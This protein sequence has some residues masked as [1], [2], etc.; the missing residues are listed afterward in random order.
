MNKKMKLSICVVAYNEEDFL[1]NLIDDI[2]KQK[3]PHDLTE[4]VLIDSMST[5]GTKRIMKSFQRNNDFYSVQVLDNPGKIQ[6]A[7]WNVAIKNATG[8]VISRIDA[9]TILPA[10]F[11][12]LVM[13]NIEAGEDVVGGIRPCVIE[14]DDDWG[15]ILLQVEN[16]LFGSSVN[17][18]RRS[19]EKQ[20]V[21]TMFHASYR[22]EVFEKVGLFNENLLR[23]EDNEMHY[24]IRQA[25]YKLC[26][27]PEIVSYQYARSSLKKTIKQKY[28]NGYWIGITLK[29]CPGCISPYHLVPAAFVG[30]I[31]GTSVL[32]VCKKTGLA[33]L[34]WGAY[35]A[36]A[37]GN[38]I[39]S[40]KNEK[41]NKFLPAMPLLFLGLHTSYGVGTI[42]GGLQAILNSKEC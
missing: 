19:K 16:S 9:H 2:K 6:A 12:A 4:V 26:Y 8:D 34:M 21:K 36:F 38:T 25:G 7:G 24:R 3:Y 18:S 41:H 32:A 28:G 30:G 35:G 11:S 37:I 27:D 33:K 23:T 17:A 5:D 40:A 31:V 14:N 20:Y 13:K 39:I 29:E 22:K 10:D 42:I 15:R 1:P